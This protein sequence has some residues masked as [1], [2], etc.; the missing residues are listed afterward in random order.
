LL[1]TLRQVVHKKPA[2]AKRAAGSSKLVHAD[3]L[4]M[5]IYEIVH[6]CAAK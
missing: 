1:L 6:M 2:L 5:K 3:H 4:V